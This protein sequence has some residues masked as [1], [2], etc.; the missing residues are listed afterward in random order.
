MAFC[1]VCG[2]P[3][4]EHRSEQLRHRPAAAAG[5]HGPRAAPRGAELVGNLTY[6]IY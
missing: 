5:A 6:F 1:S 3:R 4:D 2:G